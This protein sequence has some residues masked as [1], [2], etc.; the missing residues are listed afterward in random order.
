MRNNPAPMPSS[1]HARTTALARLRQMDRM[2]VRGPQLV[3][4]VFQALRE[5]VGFD[6]GGYVHPGDDGELDVH[7]E[8]PGLRAT[9]PHYFTP[10]I[11][12]SERSLFHRSLRQFDEAVRHERGPL[13]LEQL[14]KV[15]YEA[16]LGSDFYDVLLRPAGVSTWASLVLRTP[17]GEGVG[18]LILYRGKRAPAFRLDELRPLALLESTLARLLRPDEAEPA[19]VDVVAR[20]LLVATRDGRVQWLSPEAG[21][22][23]GQAFGWRWR[24][25]DG[26]L[27][28]P[29][30]GIVLE[31]GEAGPP[32][33]VRQLR[34]R[35]T[36]GC[37]VLRATRL[38]AANGGHDAVAL[39]IGR[40]ATDEDRLLTALERLGLPARQHELAWWLARGL[41]EARIAERMGVSPN[42]VVYHRRQLYNR[43]GLRDRRALVR[44]LEAA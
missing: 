35:T 22:L 43:L 44:R 17:R 16:L 38:A 27:P 1:A 41:P 12:R 15:P 36:T 24:G 21:E 5:V 14:L 34:L 8:D 25:A 11:L 20:G 40:C 2:G 3:A 32:G 31:S 39:E 13:V 10:E 26:P 33:P 37:F 7:M 4:Q 28:G 29:V 30:R 42:T 23:M 9:V 18:T 6:A 19:A